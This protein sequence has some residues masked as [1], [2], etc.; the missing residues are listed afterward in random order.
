MIVEVRI[1]VPFLFLAS[2]TIAKLWT[3]YLFGP[4][5]ETPPLLAA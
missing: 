5:N 3:A 1:F 4:G 2:P